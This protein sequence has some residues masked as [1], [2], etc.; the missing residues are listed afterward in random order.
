MMLLPPELCKIILYMC[1]Y[2]MFALYSYHLVM[3]QYLQMHIYMETDMD[4][5]HKKAFKLKVPFV[6]SIQLEYIGQ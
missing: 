5:C 4:M 1:T 2:I 3:Q 6:R